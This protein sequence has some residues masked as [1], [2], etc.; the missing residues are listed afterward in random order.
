MYG[1]WCF[2]SQN[3]TITNGRGFLSANW[4]YFEGIFKDQKF[5]KGR[6]YSRL[7]Q[8]TTYGYISPDKDKE[9]DF[10]GLCCIVGDNVSLTLKQFENYPVVH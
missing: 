5:Q 2:S 4:I 6:L 3:K 10:I 8:E 9:L 1:E 7:R